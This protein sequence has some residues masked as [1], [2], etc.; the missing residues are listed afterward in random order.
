MISLNNDVILDLETLL[1]DADGEQD[2]IPYLIR[3]SLTELGYDVYNNLDD[4]TNENLFVEYDNQLI[5]IDYYLNVEND[6]FNVVVKGIGK[7]K[8]KY[9]HISTPTSRNDTFGKLFVYHNE[10]GDVLVPV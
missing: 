3:V 2:L 8:P 1:D 10:N 7:Y 6:K 9:Y 5:P 4:I